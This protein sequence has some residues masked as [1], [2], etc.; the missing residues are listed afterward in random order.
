M[1]DIFEEHRELDPFDGLDRSTFEDESSYI[2][3]AIEQ[4]LKFSDPAYQKAR[5]K[6]IKMRRAQLEAEAIEKDRAEHEAAVKAYQLSGYE[7]QRVAKQAQELAAQEIAS[8]RISSD[9]LNERIQ[10]HTAKLTEQTKRTAVSN[11][12]M[13]EKIKAQ[14]MGR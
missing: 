5:A 10:H 11:M 9:R 2:A 6:V 7:K 1:R 13:N 12:R 14:M 4:E 8:G 3:A